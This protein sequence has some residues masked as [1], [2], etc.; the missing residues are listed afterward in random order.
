ME[1]AAEYTTIAKLIMEYALQSPAD[2][3]KMEWPGA[4]PAPRA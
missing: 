1:R 2:S 3:H 4:S